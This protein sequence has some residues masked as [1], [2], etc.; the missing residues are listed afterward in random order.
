MGERLVQW[1]RRREALLQSSGNSNV[2]F[3]NVK[4]VDLSATGHGCCF[5]VADF[6]RSADANGICIIE[7]RIG[8]IAVLI[9]DT[10]C[11]EGCC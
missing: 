6:E 10:G 5:S 7:A 4:E 9:T 1:Q 2:I 8:T 11:A 3:S